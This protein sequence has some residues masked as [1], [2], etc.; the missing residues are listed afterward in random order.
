MK[1][2]MQSITQAVDRNK[3]PSSCSWAPLNGCWDR[4]TVTESSR[5]CCSHTLNRTLNVSAG[6]T[7]MNTHTVPHENQCQRAFF[8]TPTTRR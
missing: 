1:A 7:P 3:A 2:N 8:R 5:R 4:E 6:Q